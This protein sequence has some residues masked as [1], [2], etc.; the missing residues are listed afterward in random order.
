M[1][2]LLFFSVIGG[3]VAFLLIHSAVQAAPL[4]ESASEN[5]GL[6]VVELFTSQGCSSCP[7][8]DTLLGDLVRDHAD[9]VLALSYHVDYWN[10]IGWEDPFSSAASTNRQRRY[11]AHLSGRVYTPQMVI[12][13]TYETIGSQRRPVY[14]FIERASRESPHI[15][16]SLARLANDML[17]IQVGSGVAKAKTEILLVSF[18]PSRT[19]EISRG[20]NGGRSLTNHHIVGMVKKIGEW[21]GNPTR[22]SIPKPRQEGVAILLQEASQGPIL[23]AAV[24]Q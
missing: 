14:D 18:E 24:L 15:P 10:Y 23:G 19:T 8:A 9:N 20:E 2:M 17:E 12:N 16:M 21:D 11:A 3:I 22:L 13:G 1:K 4:K 6:T 5:T 7:P